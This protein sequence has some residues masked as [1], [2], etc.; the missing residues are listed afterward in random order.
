MSRRSHVTPKASSKAADALGP[1]TLATLPRRWDA[2]AIAGLVLAVIAVYCPPSLLMGGVRLVGG[3]FTTLHQRRIEFAQAALL[4]MHPHL[5]GWYPREFLGTP[6]WSNLQNFPLLPTRLLL[7]PFLDSWS[8]F[9]AAVNVAA[10]LAAVFTF[11]FCRTLGL[12]RL[13]AATAG[14]TF[15]C[16]GF[17]SARVLAGHLPFL[18]AYPAFPLL[19]WLAE[20][21]LRTDGTTPRRSDIVWLGLAAGCTALAGHPQLPIYALAATLFYIVLR[22]AGRRE[23]AVAAGSL[24][25]GLLCAS[26]ALVPMAMLVG[27]STRVL[28]L[29][30]ADNDL[31]FPAHRL[32]AFVAPWADG[33]PRAARP[34]IPAASPAP[35]ELDEWLLL[36]TTCYVGLLPLAALP[37]L[38]VCALRARRFPARPWLILAAFSVAALIFAL[39]WA[40]NTLPAGPWTLLR[41]PARQI[42]LT[43]FA[44]SLTAGAGADALSRRRLASS[45]SR[46]RLTLGAL[47]AGLVVF[48]AVDL[49]RH[50][51]AFVVTRPSSDESAEQVADD[52]ADPTRVAIDTMLSHPLNRRVDD[53]GVFDSILLAGPYRALLALGGLPTRLNKQYF[54]GAEFGERGLAWSG[55]KMVLTTRDHIAGLTISQ[56]GGQL[57][58][59]DVPA[60]FPRAGFVPLAGVRY[61]TDDAVFDL[62]RAG[63]RPDPATVFLQPAVRQRLNALTTGPA[64]LSAPRVEYR[65]PSSDEIDLD[66]QVD[67]AGVIRVLESWDPGWHATVD[68]RPTEVLVADGFVM[69]IPAHAGDRAIQLVYRTPGIAAGVAL[70]LVGLLSLVSLAHFGTRGD[71]AT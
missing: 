64:L 40:R 28:D 33:W 12:G 27:R 51:K 47:L 15:A 18:E 25:A 56:R 1:A 52:P 67:A 53:V 48:Q 66:L 43:T 21:C 60:A 63:A 50:A 4:G 3:D 35:N 46:V 11:Q 58:G 65:R 37:G 61:E 69:A 59:Y 24:V 39:P 5:P 2:I 19:L 14:W 68:G 36:D 71:S 23:T 8:V 49:G 31:A 9:P 45:S 54:D 42:Y 70:S 20:R 22:G 62:M 7:V 55:A 41:S 38:G 26:F 29:D 16:A 17:F 32:K 10:A 44:L 30:R 6:F 34:G 13:G 57:F